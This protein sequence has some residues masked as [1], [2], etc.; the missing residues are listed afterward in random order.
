MHKPDICNPQQVDAYT[1][2]ISLF[3]GATLN[4]IHSSEMI[5]TDALH[6]QN[7][8]NFNGARVKAQAEA[9]KPDPSTGLAGRP[10][11]QPVK[12]EL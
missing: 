10:I 6:R 11:L 4:K 9:W 7:L 8:L 2:A 1:A 12:Q 3:Y 5:L